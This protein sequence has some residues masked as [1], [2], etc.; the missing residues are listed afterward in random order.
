LGS[1]KHIIGVTMAKFLD[2][3]LTLLLGLFFMFSLVLMCS[4]AVRQVTI[5]YEEVLKPRDEF[6][7]A[8]KL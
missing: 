7:I 4:I 2:I 6:G 5:Q 3:M 8:G 1:R